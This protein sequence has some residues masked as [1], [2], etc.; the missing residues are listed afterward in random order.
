M[1]IFFLLFL[2]IG[3]SNRKRT[4]TGNHES[5]FKMLKLLPY[6]ITAKVQRNKQLLFLMF[7]GEKEENDRVKKKVGDK[8]S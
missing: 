2:Y 1:Y 3:G 6:L 4:T 7:R 8:K 5:D